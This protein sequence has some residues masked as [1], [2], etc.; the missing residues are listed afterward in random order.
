MAPKPR[1]DRVALEQE[2]ERLLPFVGGRNVSYSNS[3]AT[4]LS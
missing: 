4:R 1:V 3:I 2:T